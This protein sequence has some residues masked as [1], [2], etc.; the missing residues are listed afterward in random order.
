MLVVVK[1]T[2]KSKYKNITD[3]VSELAKA[4]INRYSIVDITKED[5]ELIKLSR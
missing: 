5:E 3:V 1:A 2:D 4:K